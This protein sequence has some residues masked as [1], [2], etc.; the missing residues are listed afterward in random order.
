MTTQHIADLLAVV[1][2][3]LAEMDAAEAVERETEAEMREQ[4][5]RYGC[6]VDALARLDPEWNDPA[7]CLTKMKALF[8]EASSLLDGIEE[9]VEQMVTLDDAA[10][11][12]AM[13]VH[14]GDERAAT[15]GLAAYGGDMLDAVYNR[16]QTLDAIPPKRR[17]TTTPVV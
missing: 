16:A 14:R 15:N 10:L 1:T 8:L 17:Q 13:V 4:A 3:R 2:Q 9:C 6:L 12:A 11:T 7:A 5:F